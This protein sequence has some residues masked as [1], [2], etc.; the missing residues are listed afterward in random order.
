[1]KSVFFKV[2]FGPEISTA[3][4]ALCFFARVYV[5]LIFGTAGLVVGSMA[6]DR[7][8][9]VSVLKYELATPVVKAGADVGR[10]VGVVRYR[11]CETTAQVTIVDAAGERLA[12]AGV[13][14]TSPGPLNVYDE[15]IQ[16]VRVPQGAAVGK[17]TLRVSVTYECNPFHQLWPIVFENPPLYFE[18]VK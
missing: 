2:L 16:R 12:Y 10:R 9:P 13:S 18:I 7:R 4:R 3:S 11:R 8:L 17:A 6:A 15:Y 14:L 1:M 5:W